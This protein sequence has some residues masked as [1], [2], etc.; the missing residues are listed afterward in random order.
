MENNP[1][2]EI[3][4][5]KLVVNIGTGGEQAR[6]QSAA[7]LLELL[8][9]RKPSQAAA[10]K[11]N[12]AFKISKGHQIGAFVTVRGDQIMPLAK[13][14]FESIDNRIKQSSIADN[15]VSFGIREYI[16]ISGIKY[17]PKI[18]MLG[19]N[20]NLSFRR[21]GL[22]VALRKRKRAQIPERHRNIARGEIQEYL[23]KEFS[24]DLAE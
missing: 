5:D 9:G 12:P 13:R 24:V 11:R 1:M 20:V 16:D 15:S 17:D 7:K 22:R 18:G 23:K 8:T 6:N 21:K 19:M 3:M 14:L 10:K 2:K 4:I